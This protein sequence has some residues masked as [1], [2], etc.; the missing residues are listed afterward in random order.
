MKTYIARAA[1]RIRA[2]AESFDRREA[3]GK[4]MADYDLIFAK[5][6]AA[7]DLRGARA[8]LDKLVDM[9]DLGAAVRV[10]AASEPVEIIVTYEDRLNDRERA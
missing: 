6:M 5:Q 9:L 8:T 1:S 3:L 7:G 4:A 2:V 10:D